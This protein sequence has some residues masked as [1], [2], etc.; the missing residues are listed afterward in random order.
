[1]KRLRTNYVGSRVTH[2]N[3][4]THCNYFSHRYY[5]IGPGIPQFPTTKEG[6]PITPLGVKSIKIDKGNNNNEETKE[7][8]EIKRILITGGNGNLGTKLF[9][10]WR[11]RHS[12]T[13]VDAAP[14]NKINQ[15]CL[16]NSR[17]S[18][19]YIQSFGFF[20][21]KKEQKHFFM[22]LNA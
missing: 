15:F 8:P 19:A 9:Q 10:F 14:P 2:K 4:V 21:K 22:I 5:G 16:E 1:M 11:N 6:I 13:I 3:I 12:I 7:K 17:Q 20:S 18:H